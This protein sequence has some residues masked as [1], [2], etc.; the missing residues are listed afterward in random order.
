MVIAFW[1]CVGLIMY[2]YFAYPLFLYILSKISRKEDSSN[3]V[4]NTYKNYIPTVSMVI[5]AYNEEKVIRDKM[6]NCM[7]IDYPKGKFEIIVG[8]DGS[9]D[10]TNEIV[11]SYEISGVKLINYTDRR[12]KISVL[13]RTV[14]QASGEIVVLSDANTIYEPD[15][16]RKLIRHF[17]DK[18][19]GVVCG[20]LILLTKDKKQ[21][22]EGYYWK[23]ECMLKAMESKLGALLGANGGIYALRKELFEPIPDNTIVDD[24]V[25]AMKVKEKGFDIIFEQEAIAYEDAAQSIKAEFGRRVRIGAGCFQAIPMTKRLLNPMRGSIAFA[26][27]SHKIIRWIVP[28]LLAIAF[29]SNI[30]LLNNLFYLILF[31]IQLLFYSAALIGHVLGNRKSS[32]L[33][34]IPYYLGSMNLAL[35]FGFFR[36]VTKTQ[37]VTWKRT[38]R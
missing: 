7:A 9:S 2:T 14:P 1:V 11:K 12:G 16:V 26:Y 5:A 6:E 13:N 36:F 3:Y 15:A 19:I 10:R 20:K 22:E 37:K 8:S 18:R 38:E 34:S 4:I 24:F 29:V 30:I 17:N 23:Y 35:L 27:W 32:R 25:I 28:F 33:F 31:V 21:A